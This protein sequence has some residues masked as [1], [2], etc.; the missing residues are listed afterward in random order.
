VPNVVD[1]VVAASD[2]AAGIIDQGPWA[3]ALVAVAWFAARLVQK[4]IARGWTQH[5]AAIEQLRDTIKATRE[6]RDR[7]TARADAAEARAAALERDYREKVV[8]VL[9]DVYRVLA[10]M[11]RGRGG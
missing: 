11:A 6:D 3:A 10:D 4:V 7:E 2:P 1:A 8:P 9:T 5:D